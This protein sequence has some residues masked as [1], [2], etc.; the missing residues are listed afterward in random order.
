MDR[1][2]NSCIESKHHKFKFYCFQCALSEFKKLELL[3]ADIYLIVEITWYVLD[4]DLDSFIKTLKS[5]AELREKPIFLILTHYVC[6]W[7]SKVRF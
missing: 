5:S 7:G 4:D 3:D 6:D 1:L 2:Q